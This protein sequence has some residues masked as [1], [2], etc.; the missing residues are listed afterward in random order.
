LCVCLILLPSTCFRP[1]PLLR[2]LA[3]GVNDD[4]KGDDKGVSK[5]PVRVATDE[6]VK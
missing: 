3:Q 2:I 6:V 4:E 5:T 1:N